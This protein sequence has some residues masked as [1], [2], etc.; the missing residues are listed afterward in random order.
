MKAA[1]TPTDRR[2]VVMTGAGHADRSRLQ[3]RRALQITLLDELISPD[4]TTRES[5]SDVFGSSLPD[6]QT[7]RR[8]GR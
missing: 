5:Q 8:G 6:V 1:V 7:V 4:R 2:S 3:T